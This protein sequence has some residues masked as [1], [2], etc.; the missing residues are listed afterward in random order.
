MF[1]NNIYSSSI[2][3]SVARNI[4]NHVN[5]MV[6][7]LYFVGLYSI[8]A[9][10]HVTKITYKISFAVNVVRRIFNVCFYLQICVNQSC[11]SIFPHIETGRCP[12]N[13]NNLECS[14]HGVRF[15]SIF[16]FSFSVYPQK[17][18]TYLTFYSNICCPTHVGFRYSIYLWVKSLIFHL[19]GHK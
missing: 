9:C 4:I 2:I 5:D 18:I 17:N 16:Y 14:G 11:T 8:Y 6:L 1:C 10:N 19:F 12:S 15:L 7:K 3:K 13:H